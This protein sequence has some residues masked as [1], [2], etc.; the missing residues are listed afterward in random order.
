MTTSEQADATPSCDIYDLDR[1]WLTSGSIY[2]GKVVAV[3]A[4]QPDPAQ[5]GA[6][7][8]DRHRE[9]NV[10]IDFELEHILKGYLQ[11]TSWNDHVSPEGY[12]PG[13]F[14]VA[15]ADHYTLGSEIFYI[16][17]S[18]GDMITDYAC[19][20][21]I[22]KVNDGG[23]QTLPDDFFDHFEEIYGFPPPKDNPCSNPDHLLVLREN[24]RLACVKPLTAEKKNWDI[25]D[26]KA[27]QADKSNR[28]AWAAG[29]ALHE[30]DSLP[31]Y[32]TD[33]HTVIVG[34]D[35][36][37]PVKDYI[38]ASNPMPDMSMFKR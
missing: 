10:R 13:D 21:G 16:G 19:G 14:C 6:G 33:L 23:R 4:Q 32:Y 11:H 35:Q 37:L 24:D 7:A 18:E 5:N 30:Y 25:F 17:S 28:Q 1:A 38:L 20:I 9:H 12:C 31:I 8:T 22:S 15:G 26:M 29:G 2:T 3:I 27:Y 36:M 34:S